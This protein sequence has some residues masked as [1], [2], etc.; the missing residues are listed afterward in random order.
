[1]NRRDAEEQR[2]NPRYGN[3]TPTSGFAFCLLLFA[4]LLQLSCS[5]K[6]TDMRS[7]VPADTL[8]YLETNDL[9]AAIQPI[10]DSKPFNEVAKYKPDISAIKGVQLAVAVTGF[11]TTEEKLTDEQSVGNIRPHFVA[12]ADTHAWNWQAVGFAEKKLGSFVGNIYNSE[13]TVEQTD[14]NGGKYFTWTAKDGRKAYA[15]V[16][17]SLIYFAND[18]SSIDKCLAVKRGETDSI[19]K[20]GKVTVSEPGTLA[21]GYVG[22]DGIAQ[23]ANIVGLK[24]GSEASD[25][26]EVQTA[27]VSILPQLLR[28]SITRISWTAN[29]TDLGIEDKYSIEMPPEL[30]STLHK[31]MAPVG[32]M[33]FEHTEILKAVPADV[34]SVTLYNLRD[35]LEAW[36]T[37][38]STAQKQSGPMEG[39]YIPEFASLLLEPYGIR[40]PQKFL[41]RL[42][43]YIVT[44]KFGDDSEKVVAI[45]EEIRDGEISKKSE[46]IHKTP[47]ITLIEPNIKTN[48]E[49]GHEVYTSEDGD[50]KAMIEGPIIIGDSGG[51]SKCLT[52]LNAPD[53]FSTLLKDRW[54]AFDNDYPSVLSFGKDRESFGLIARAISD[55]KSDGS[56]AESKFTTET[57]FNK[58]G[59]ERRSF[60]DF[61]L[62]GSIIAQL[63]SD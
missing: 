48:N 49:A 18:E 63:N 5:T 46:E 58:D 38:I 37:L 24:L 23:I 53:N 56:Q 19:A 29:K 14:K 41:L 2:T 47:L 15:L 16:I 35:P 61:G 11:E 60:S 27:I 10:I 7:L 52:S 26:S 28:N 45:A 44:A 1:M 8:V 9:G 57:K 51:V 20:A 31:A 4:F 33:I 13:P 62:I 55:V 6:P 22:P 50:L 32:Q 30:A 36:Q 59:I 40:D 17:G 21:S 39:Q 34:S 25:E 43:D 42:Q 3:A 12:I 54:L